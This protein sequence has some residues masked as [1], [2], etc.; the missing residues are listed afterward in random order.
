MEIKLKKHE[1]NTREEIQE[2]GENRK[3]KGLQIR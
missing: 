2:R 3:E 1:R